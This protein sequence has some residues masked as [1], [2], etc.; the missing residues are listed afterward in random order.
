MLTKYN[1]YNY[2]AG[3]MR[4]DFI[5]FNSGFRISTGLHFST[6]SLTRTTFTS[7]TFRTFKIKKYIS[8]YKTLQ[9]HVIYIILH[10]YMKVLAH[11]KLHFI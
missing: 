7:T 5:P 10:V 2:L 11:A 3:A 8:I 1:I 6:N 9:L 4:R